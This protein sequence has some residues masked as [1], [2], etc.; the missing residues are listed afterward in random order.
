MQRKNKIDWEMPEETILQRYK[1]VFPE[2]SE[3]NLLNN[4]KY[5]KLIYEEKRK[6]KSKKVNDDSEK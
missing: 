1:E 5:Q 6:R 2:K 4:I 3:E